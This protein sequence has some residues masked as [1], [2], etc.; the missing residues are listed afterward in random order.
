MELAA[1]DKAILDLIWLK[2]DPLEEAVNLPSTHIIAREILDDLE[3]AMGEI[4]AIVD[5]LDS[6]LI[7]SQDD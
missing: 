1:R 6:Q 7:K 5:A 3:S 4:S 2:D